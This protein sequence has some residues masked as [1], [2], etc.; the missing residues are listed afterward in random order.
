[1]ASG[2][3]TIP[4]RSVHGLS[5]ACP[6]AWVAFCRTDRGWKE[7]N[8]RGSDLPRT[9][10]VWNTPCWSCK[11]DSL[12]PVLPG[13]AMALVVVKHACRSSAA[14][15]V[16]VSEAGQVR[17]LADLTFGTSKGKLEQKS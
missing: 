4:R 1:M 8:G 12:K 6:Q 13:R 3:P 9:G 17:V 16:R 2:R 11:R 7:Y 15:T 14:V 10:P 5:P